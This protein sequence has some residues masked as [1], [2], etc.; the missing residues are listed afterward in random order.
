M[1]EY[2]PGGGG[3]SREGGAEEGGWIYPRAA[4][5]YR[6]R[7]EPLLSSSGASRGAGGGG[8]GG[9][10]ACSDRAVC[11]AERA[12]PPDCCT[13]APQLTS[14][15]SPPLRTPPHLHPSSIH[16]QVSPA[17][18]PRETWSA[19]KQ[20]ARGFDDCWVRRAK[21]RT[22]PSPA[23]LITHPLSSMR[24][25]PC[26]MHHHPRMHRALSLS[27]PTEACRTTPH[28]HCIHRHGGPRLCTLGSVPTGSP[29]PSLP[30][31]PCAAP[32]PHHYPT[33]PP[34]PPHHPHHHPT[35][36]PPNPRHPAAAAAAAAAAAPARTHTHAPSPLSPG[37]G[38]RRAYLWL[39]RLAL[40]RRR[41]A[42]RRCAGRRRRRRRQARAG[43][44]TTTTTTITAR[45]DL[46]AA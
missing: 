24:H 8:A 16:P 27:L 20:Q 17:Y 26:T 29:R 42:R 6:G 32:H 13:L 33:T 40:S 15:T 3:C 2:T 11:H 35:T 37:T 34:S 4:R 25:A 7:S 9:G 45:K 18:N 22:V 19:P 30:R 36:Q 23:Y 10:G 21:H 28:T 5:A 1:A 31:R 12:P 43:G 41:A 14:L 39:A 46:V 44:L 38:A